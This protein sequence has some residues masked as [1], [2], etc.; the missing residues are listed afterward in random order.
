[1]HFHKLLKQTC[2][3][4]VYI[5]RPDCVSLC[6]WFSAAYGSQLLNKLCNKCNN[7]YCLQYVQLHCDMHIQFINR[8]L[9]SCQVNKPQLSN[10][11]YTSSMV[12]I[13]GMFNNN[14][15]YCMAAATLLHGEKNACNYTLLQHQYSKYDVMFVKLLVQNHKLK[16]GCS[17]CS[18]QSG[19]GRCTFSWSTPHDTQ[20]PVCRITSQLT[21]FCTHRQKN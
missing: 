21:T 4:L 16:Q 19:F 2:Q 15:E 17:T 8:P 20:D 18:S 10:S 9:R 3:Q 13:F 12:I 14:S 6:I 5:C 1:M 11:N 7:I